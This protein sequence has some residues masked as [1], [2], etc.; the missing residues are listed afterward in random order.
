MTDEG[1]KS[2]IVF[3]LEFLINILLLETILS[4]VPLIW[5]ILVLIILDGF[6]WWLADQFDW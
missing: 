1:L 6:G 4:G 3:I 2:F 5:Q